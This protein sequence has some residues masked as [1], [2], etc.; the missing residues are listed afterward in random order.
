M[1]AIAIENGRRIG[2]LLEV[3]KVSNSSYFLMDVNDLSRKI[4]ITSLRN[5]FSGDKATS[6]KSNLY[7]SC[8]KIDE[9]LENINDSISR[10]RKDIDNMNNRMDEIY[11]TLGGDLSSIRALI[12]KYYTELTT[13]DEE[14]DRKYSQRT[15]EL[16]NRITQEV[17]TLNTTIVNTKTEL[18]NSIQNLDTKLTA[19]INKEISNREAAINKEIRDRETAIN[20][21]QQNLNIEIQNRKDADNIL[22]QSI[23]NSV[24]TIN[25]SIIAINE[26][27][28]YIT[29]FQIGTSV[30]SNLPNGVVYFQYFN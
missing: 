4:S 19:A 30:P 17:S 20:T 10:I 23:N 28:K 12:N 21:L 13:A 22:Q 1:S 5:S 14:L 9:F 25:Q 6:N 26:K 15:T 2:E 3:T 27:L 18:N 24:K 29:Q 16:D 8:E 7:Y 11:E